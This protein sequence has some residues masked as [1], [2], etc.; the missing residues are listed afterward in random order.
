MD[1]F[2]EI[3]NAEFER[4][5]DTLDRLARLFGL[6]DYRAGEPQPMDRYELRNFDFEPIR[7]KLCN[8]NNWA[9]EDDNIYVCEH[10]TIAGLIRQL[11]SVNKRHVMSA[12]LI[13]NH[14]G[15]V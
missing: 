8:G 2:D 13:G 10:G 3:A 4:T 9:I 14:W 11:D 7:C 6:D 15:L 12:R 5:T 1:D